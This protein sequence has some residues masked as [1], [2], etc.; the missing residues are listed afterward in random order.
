LGQ[1]QT[2]ETSSSVPLGSS[3][4]ANA[5]APVSARFKAS[6][7]SCVGPEATPVDT[8]RARLCRELCPRICAALMR[9]IVRGAPGGEAF[10]APA[11]QPERQ[12]RTGHMRL[13]FG[14]IAWPKFVRLGEDPRVGGCRIAEREPEHDHCTWTLHMQS[15]PNCATGMISRRVPTMSECRSTM[16]HR[17]PCRR[18]LVNP[19]STAVD[20]A[21]LD[22]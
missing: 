21:P 10:A 19:S 13:S 4:L 15:P 7:N 18:V 1:A 2:C 3:A 14:R 20:S 6:A 16:I 17:P 5:A 11:E 12:L 22:R 9:A 8:R